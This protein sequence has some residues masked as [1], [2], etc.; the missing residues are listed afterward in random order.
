M[1]NKWNSG[2]KD[3]E[4]LNYLGYSPVAFIPAIDTKFLYRAN[5]KSIIPYEI[6][7]VSKLL[8]RPLEKICSLFMP[9]KLIRSGTLREDNRGSVLARLKKFS[10]KLVARESLF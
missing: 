10:S 4:F 5:Y 7:E 9:E 3:K 8:D 2:V 6:T 1:V